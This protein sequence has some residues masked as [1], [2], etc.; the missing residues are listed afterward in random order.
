MGRKYRDIL[1]NIINKLIFR[2][3]KLVFLKYIVI[4]QRIELIS[5]DK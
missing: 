2:T 4:L 5:I 3:K 1:A